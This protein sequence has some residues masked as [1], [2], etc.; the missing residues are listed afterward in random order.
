M[1]P[2]AIG[3]AS[4]DHQAKTVF[5]GLCSYSSLDYVR[6]GNRFVLLYERGVEDP[7]DGGIAAA[8]FDPEWL[9]G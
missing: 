3:R 4:G 8:E 2:I 9:L 1:I 5:P 6:E 7:C